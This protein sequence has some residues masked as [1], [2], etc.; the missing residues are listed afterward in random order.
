MPVLDCALPEVLSEAAS[1][2][3]SERA[4]KY[5]PNPADNPIR[6]LARRA[7]A[8]DRTTQVRNILKETVHGDAIIMGLYDCVIR[9]CDRHQPAAPQRVIPSRRSRKLPEWTE[10]V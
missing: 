4:R 7:Y 5:Y 10:A 9:A 2:T 1:A 6:L 8:L 3:L